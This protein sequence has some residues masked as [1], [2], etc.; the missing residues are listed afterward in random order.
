MLE[1]YYE[2]DEI[3]SDKNGC[4]HFFDIHH[5]ANFPPP[6][7]PHMAPPLFPNALK[8]AKQMKNKMMLNYHPDK[9]PS[10]ESQEKEK[11]AESCAKINKAYEN[12]AESAEK[13]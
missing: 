7:S 8:H 3:I 11:A 6:E 13:R 2:V 12:I 9:V 4:Y 10:Q 1:S 5:E